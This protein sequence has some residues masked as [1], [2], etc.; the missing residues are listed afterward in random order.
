MNRH[1]Y[2]RHL[3]VWALGVDT[4]RCETLGYAMRLNVQGTGGMHDT[5]WIG[6]WTGDTE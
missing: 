6:T 5:E 3:E 2:V 4:W 1:G